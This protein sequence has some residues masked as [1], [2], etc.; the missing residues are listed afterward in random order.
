M[1]FLGI[2]VLMLCRLSRSF[3]VPVDTIIVKV[4]QWGVMGAQRVMEQV[5]L[6]G[7]PL[8]STSQEVSSIIQRISAGS[9]IPALI[10][11]NKTSVLRNH[12]VLWS[13]ECILEGSQLHWRDRVFYDG[14]VNLTLNQTDMWT[15][16]VLHAQTL[17][18]LWYQDVQ[19][20]RT[21]RIR[22]QEGCIK[23]MREFSLSEEHSVPGISLPQFLIP[24]LAF[25]ALSGLIVINLLLFKNH[26]L[27][28]PGGVVGSIIHY[29]KDMTEMASEIKGSGYR[30]L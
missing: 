4:Q 21:E 17:K 13:C 8:T 1:H 11:D 7:V 15:A 27:R 20:T 24:V 12:T 5:F 18:L 9:P 10:S 25:L 22:L 29:P 16:H 3:P 2:F 19:R 26:G 30:T 14:K 23:L 28:H 6:N